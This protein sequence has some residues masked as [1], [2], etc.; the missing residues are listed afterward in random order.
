MVLNFAEQKCKLKEKT[1]SK[2]G[3]PTQTYVNNLA[4][5]HILYF[6]WKFYKINKV[7]ITNVAVVEI[8]SLL[9]GKISLLMIL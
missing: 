1:E 7:S 4:S 6:H 9:H 8:S 3:N 5:D 2:M